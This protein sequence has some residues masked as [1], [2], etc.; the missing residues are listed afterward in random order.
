LL[1]FRSFLN[2]DPPHLAE[3]WRTRSGLR[4]YAQPMTAALLERLVL[5]KPYFDPHGL[6][7]AT[8][9]NRPV[10]FA[11]AGFG[12]TEDESSISHD[13]GASILTIVA[14]HTE[15]N[16]IAAGLIAR[17][18]EYLRSSGSKVLYGGGMRPLNSFYLGLYGGS[19]LSGILDSDLQQQTFFRTAGYREID[20]TIVMHRELAGFRPLVD[21]QQMQV[22]RRTRIE[23]IF[24]PACRTW[25]EACTIGDYNRIQYKLFLRESESE[26]AALATLLEM[27]AFSHTWGVRTAGLLDVLVDERVRRQGLA[28]NL[29][30]DMLRRAAEQ[31]IGL[32]EV[33]TMQKNAAAI[34]MYRKLGFQEVDQGTVFRKD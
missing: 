30:G 13:L 24:D 22:K 11:H 9:D 20:R 2:S 3:I 34:A 16:Q 5:A 21:R 26:P 17:S 33:Q 19:E 12:P 7:V 10:G 27:E 31:G 14:P 18:E 1:G 29:L 15:E 6:L 4:G 32:I 23:S 28:V 25:W 8:D